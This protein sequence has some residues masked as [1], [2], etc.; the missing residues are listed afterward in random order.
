MSG[1]KSTTGV[2]ID[3]T[4]FLILCEVSGIKNGEGYKNMINLFAGD[5]PEAFIKMISAKD[6]FAKNNE[7]VKIIGVYSKTS[8]KVVEQ[9]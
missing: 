8:L 1:E 7:E 4:K 9:K 2:D 3:P 5:E 6:A